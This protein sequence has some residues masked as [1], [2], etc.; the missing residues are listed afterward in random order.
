MQNAKNFASVDVDAL[1]EVKIYDIKQF[2]SIYIE[3][4]ICYM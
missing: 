2:D 4:D 1:T 3:N